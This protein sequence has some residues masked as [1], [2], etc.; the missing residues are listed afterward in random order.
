MR[1]QLDGDKMIEAR[2]QAVFAAFTNNIDLQLIGKPQFISSIVKANRRSQNPGSSLIS[3][4]E[5][6]TEKIFFHSDA[7]CR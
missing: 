5:H 7:L 6:R 3:S 2:I 4:T 1:C